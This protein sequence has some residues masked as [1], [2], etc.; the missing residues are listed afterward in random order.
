ML[1]HE[2]LGAVH[3]ADVEVTP[4]DL[5][6]MRARNDELRT[7]FRLALEEAFVVGCVLVDEGQFRNGSVL[8]IGERREELDREELGE[9]DEISS[10]GSVEQAAHVV[11]E[12]VKARHW[13][14]GEVT[15]GN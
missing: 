8:P 4:V 7:L 3:V 5:H 14:D 10:L 13:T 11:G 6:E 15:G 9:E 1:E 12:L 2:T